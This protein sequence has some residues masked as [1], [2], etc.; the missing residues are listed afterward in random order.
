MNI[1]NKLFILLF[2]SS[3]TS[4]FTVV[5]N[6]KISEYLE[7]NESSQ[8]SF[9]VNSNIDERLIGLWEKTFKIIDMGLGSQ[10]L[11]FYKN[12]FVEYKKYYKDFLATELWGEFRTLSDTLYIKFNPQDLIEKILVSFNNNQLVLQN[13]ESPF[14]YHHY[15]IESY[16]SRYGFIYVGE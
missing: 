10:S 14:F 6:V 1:F 4:C 2:L 5:N 15:S 8:N 13:L 16:P 11:H 12:G 7:T 9:P 3:F